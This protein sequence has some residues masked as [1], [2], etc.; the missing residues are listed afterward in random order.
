MHSGWFKPLIK[1]HQSAPGGSAFGYCAPGTRRLCGAPLWWSRGSA[2]PGP[3]DSSQAWAWKTWPLSLLPR[4]RVSGV[5]TYHLPLPPLEPALPA[6]VPPSWGGSPST[7]GHWLFPSPPSRPRLE[8]GCHLLPPTSVSW[9]LGRALG[10]VTVTPCPTEQGPHGPNSGHSE[11]DAR[12]GS[13]S[14]PAVSGLCHPHPRPRGCVELPLSGRIS[15]LHAS[16]SAVATLPRLSGPRERR[17]SLPWL[18]TDL[19]GSVEACANPALVRSLFHPPPLS[20]AGTRGHSG[21]TCYRWRCSGKVTRLSIHSRSL[22]RPPKR[23]PALLQ[24]MTK[25]GLY[26]NLSAGQVHWY[27]T[28]FRDSHAPCLGQ[29]K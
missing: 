27:R 25:D 22:P 28:R 26:Y 16:L 6:A 7:Q 12:P 24:A 23:D 2:H 5:S 19:R 3:G 13:V 18:Q 21:R 14:G 10:T 11:A 20:P 17:E 29:A 9:A 4:R 1:G 8:P 15:T